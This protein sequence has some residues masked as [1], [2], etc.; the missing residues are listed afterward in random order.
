MPFLWNAEAKLK[1]P[2]FTFSFPKGTPDSH[3]WAE[4]TRTGIGFQGDWL[5]ILGPLAGRME[6]T[7]NLDNSVFDPVGHDV[8]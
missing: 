6:D 3:G 4:N 2:A 7:E 5:E 1:G 8:P